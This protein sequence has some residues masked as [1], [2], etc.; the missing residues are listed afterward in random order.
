MEGR[1][2]PARPVILVDDE[3][4]ILQSMKGVLQTEGITN[5]ILLED[6]RVLRDTLKKTP[7]SLDRKSVV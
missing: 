7:A 2:Y 4:N 1:R 6:S 5:V 3:R